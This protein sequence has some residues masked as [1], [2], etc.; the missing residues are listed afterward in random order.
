MKSLGLL[1]HTLISVFAVLVGYQ[2]GLPPFWVAVTMSAYWMGREIAQAE[3]RYIL[4]H[5]DTQKRAD[6]PLMVVWRTR[7]AWDVK[8]FLW[9]MVAPTFIAVSLA[10][11]L[12]AL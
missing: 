5:T 7:R 9:D 3:Y 12:E 2:I 10:F 1:L 8:S 4:Y 6:K 11:A